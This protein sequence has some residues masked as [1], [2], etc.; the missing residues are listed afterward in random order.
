M[1]HE[2]A[3]KSYGTD[4]AQLVYGRRPDGT[5]AHIGEIPRGLLGTRPRI[6]AGASQGGT[7]T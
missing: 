7:F 5:F 2:Q 6:Y 3:Q 1:D 4:R